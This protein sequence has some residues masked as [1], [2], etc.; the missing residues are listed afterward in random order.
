MNGVKE[1]NAMKVIEIP[2][3]PQ[4]PKILRVAAYAR[5]SSDKDAAFRSLETQTQYYEQYVGEHL[6]WKLVDIYSDD[7]ISGTRIDRP[8]FQRMLKDCRDKKIDLVITKSV[9][10]FA[11]NTVD[12][13]ETLRELKKL[14][15]D[16]YFEKE[17]MHSISPDGELL[18]TF[19]AMYAEEEARSASENQLWRIR[20]RFERGEP[21]IGKMLGYRL[22]GDRLVIM[23]EEAEI[24]R[25]IFTDYLSG[26][27]LAG[28]AK[29][30]VAQGISTAKGGIWAA[31]TIRCI[32]K[33]K[34]YTG[35]IILQK[36]YRENFRTKKKVVNHG[37]RRFYCVDDSHE[38]I[39]DQETF[40]KVQT[41]MERRANISKLYTNPL[42]NHNSLFS[43]LL[44]CGQCGYAYRHRWTN[45]KKYD[46]S[47]WTCPTFYSLGKDNCPSQTIP[48]DI[49][50]DKTK[51]VL[52][53]LELN[54]DL[55][56]EHMEKIIVFP[57]NK[58]KFVLKN[59]QIIDTK[60][61]HRSRRESW[62]AEMREE[63]RQ[64][65]LAQR[66]KEVNEIGTQSNDN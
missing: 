64:K 11:R 24:V 47:T 61:Q 7:G 6:D 10:R 40:D 36:T 48:E 63:A 30:L 44:Q 22:Q 23:P 33:N 58:L 13:L 57:E 32:L 59:G 26:M 4:E 29:K 46:K 43:G 55:L 2:K 8:E 65:A 37:E 54:R 66:R 3:K 21:T 62:T 15:I 14:G 49:L 1:V 5:V 50:I 19:L 20:K 16:I 53:V 18:V 60:W 9:T 12:L 52:G 42:H 39:I 35:N 45:A 17:N 41:E 51:E 38:A 56:T 31:N 34:T 25:Q 28:I 27:G